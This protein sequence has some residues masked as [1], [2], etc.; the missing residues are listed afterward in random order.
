MSAIMKI[1]AKFHEDK[2]VKPRGWDRDALI[3]FFA[4]KTGEA[5]LRLPAYTDAEL[6]PESVARNAPTGHRVPAEAFARKI[7]GE[8][9]TVAPDV[10]QKNS[11]KAFIRDNVLPNLPAYGG[12]AIAPE[13]FELHLVGTGDDAYVMVY[14]RK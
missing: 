12:P 3:A 1:V 2:R 5:F 11:L 13:Q 7:G 8:Y 10:S 14:R 4:R 6:S 9:V